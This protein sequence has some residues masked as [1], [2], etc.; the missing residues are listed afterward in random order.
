MGVDYAASR[1]WAMAYRGDMMYAVAY[2]ATLF[3][4]P[5]NSLESLLSQGVERLRATAHG[6][7]QAQGAR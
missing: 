2:T 4:L 1:A 6:G 3:A 7:R 5:V